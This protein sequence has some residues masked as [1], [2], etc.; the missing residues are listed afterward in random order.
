MCGLTVKPTA[1]FLLILVPLL[2]GCFG[3]ADDEPLFEG[4]NM[5]IVNRTDISL[6]SEELNGGENGSSRTSGTGPGE[7]IG[8]LWGCDANLGDLK[9]WS[10]AVTFKTQTG[11]FFA[12]GDYELDCTG[13]NDIYTIWIHPSGQLYFRQGEPG[14]KAPWE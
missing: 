12:R 2:G 1:L 11:Q 9:E 13:K 10:F 7:H 6:R 8:T 14:S 3:G 5:N 4:F